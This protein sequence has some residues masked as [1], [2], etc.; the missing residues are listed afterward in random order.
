MTGAV[1]RLITIAGI[2]VPTGGASRFR[3]FGAASDGIAAAGHTGIAGRAGKACA[4]DANAAQARFV[5]V[6]DIAV[7]AG[8]S[9]RHGRVRALASGGI[10]D[11]GGVAAIGRLANNGIGANAGAVDADIRLRAGIPVI[12]WRAVW[13]RLRHACAG[14]RIADAGIVALVNRRTIYRLTWDA[15]TILAGVADRTWAAIETGGAIRLRGFWF[16]GG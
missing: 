14:R 13:F 6:A 1:A 10:A 2:A 12:A 16:G 9:I 8:G 15:G 11:A 7:A 3:N 5:S 4:N